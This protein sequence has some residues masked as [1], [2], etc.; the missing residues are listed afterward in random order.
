MS[1]EKRHITLHL[2]NRELSV[3]APADEEEYYR[4]AAKRITDTV[5]TY[6]SIFH[7]S[8]LH[9]TKDDKDILYMAMLDIALR[10]EKDAPRN[11]TAPF[12]NILNQ[13]TADIDEA[14]N[15]K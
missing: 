10:L 15:E 1:N 11:D 9:G 8:V 3:N 6:E 14:L 5:N 13:L 2:Y 12:M 7:D 4:K